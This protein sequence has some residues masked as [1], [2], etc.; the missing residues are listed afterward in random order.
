MPS[1]EGKI[2]GSSEP[3][4]GKCGARLKGH[5]NPED[6][7][8]GRYCDQPAGFGTS[9]KGQ[10]T[11]KF[12]GGSVRTHIVKAERIK[13]REEATRLQQMLGA[14]ATM[15]DPYV[16]LWDLTAKVVQWM[17]IA[18]TLMAEL[19]DYH[20]TTDRAGIEHTKELIAQ[21]ERAVVM[22][23]DTLV[24][25]AKLDLSKKLLQ[26]KQDQA[27]LIAGA[28]NGMITSPELNMTDD[29]VDLA[30]LIFA[31]K[32][33]PVKGALEL[34]WLPEI[35]EVEAFEAEILNE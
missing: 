7:R 19:E 24:Q 12:H 20:P 4:E 21:W 34:H 18:E 28:I 29:Q 26:I 30:R 22:A 8:Y 25:I 6:E 16:E 17:E 1:P 27:D 2:P 10:G 33:E 5:G 11:C 13:V 15:R 23:R 9:H 3:K 35:E 14:P 32:L 31:R